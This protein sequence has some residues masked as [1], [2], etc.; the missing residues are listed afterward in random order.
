M[1]G[2][3]TLIGL[4]RRQKL[5]PGIIYCNIILTNNFDLLL[6]ID[7]SSTTGYGKKKTKNQEN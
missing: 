4:R 6:A 5:L 2:S 1:P 7:Q 3:E